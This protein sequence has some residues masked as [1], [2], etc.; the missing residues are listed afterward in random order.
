M[1]FE[2]LSTTE[3]I[4]WRLL[5]VMFLSLFGIEMLM[6]RGL[7]QKLAPLGKPLARAAR[8]PPACTVTFLA[9]FGSLI[10]ANTMLA[11]SY[12]SREIT[13]RELVLGS[14]FNTVPVHFKETLTYQLPVILPLLGLKMCLVYIATFWL[15]G[16]LKLAYV[17]LLGRKTL[18]PKDGAASAYAEAGTPAERPR[19]F[20]GLAKSAW[21]AR[22]KMFLKM[23]GLICGVT[24]LVQLLVAAGA[25]AALERAIG[26][27]ADLFR[28]PPAVVGPVSVYIL[29]PIVGVASMSSLLS[30]GMVSEYQ[31][32]VALLAGGFLMVPVSRLRSTL[33]RYVS[34]LGFRHGTRVLTITTLLSLLSRAIVLAGVLLLW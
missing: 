33:P 20:F 24:F 29:S 14:V 23:A 31:A 7:M 34:I 12:E 13:G 32:I 9:S 8:L 3:A 4:A 16:L 28:L 5:P 2:A 11:Q 21:K 15:A 18:A 22:R 30:D 10:A 19:G 26:P 27:A 17:V 6:Q 25:L 1:L